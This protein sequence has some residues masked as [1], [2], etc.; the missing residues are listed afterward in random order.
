M[1]KKSPFL[2]PWRIAALIV[3][4]LMLSGCS[5]LWGRTGVPV[6]EDGFGWRLAP[7]CQ[8]NRLG[9]MTR[10][11]CDIL[12]GDGI[13]I[14]ITRIHPLNSSPGQDRR[15]TI[16]IEFQVNSGSWSLNSPYLEIVLAGKAMPPSSLDEVIVFEKNGHKI[17]ERLEPNRKRYLLPLVEKRF[18]RFLFP[19]RQNEFEDGFH[20]KIIGLQRQDDAVRVPTL[21]FEFGK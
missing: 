9:F 5:G 19:V 2:A 3:F 11:D 20:L 14:Q 15:S 7:G 18:F 8:V 1:P 21:H 10:P 12:A 13:T 6:L 4:E 16:G 17:S